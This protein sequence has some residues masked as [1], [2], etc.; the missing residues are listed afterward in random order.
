[1]KDHE[2]IFIKRAGREQYDILSSYLYVAE[3]QEA[4]NNGDLSRA[5]ELCREAVKAR[6]NDRTLIINLSRVLGRESKYAEARGLLEDGRKG[7]VDET[8]R[9]E[10]SDEL[11][12]QDLI[13]RIVKRIEAPSGMH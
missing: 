7:C 12:R 1:L 4:E 6:P 9:R 5:E 3:A 11:A 8:C 13:E 10:Y 2:Q